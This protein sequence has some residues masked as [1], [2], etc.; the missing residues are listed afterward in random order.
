[1]IQR[2]QSL[3][4]FIAALLN[5]GML[6][7]NLYSAHIMV[8]GADTV[9]NMRINGP[10]EF[11]LLLLG[12]VIMIV[13]LVAIFMFKNRKKQKSI[14]VFSIVAVIA[15]IATLLMHVA[16][17]NNQTPA[18]ANGGYSVGAVLPVIS[19]IFLVMAIRGIN[20]DEKLVKSLDRLR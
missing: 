13:P 10:N 7:F 16:N 17:F 18:P 4:L 9:T 8:N 5:A 15:F 11:L 19:I 20:K 1:M 14:V 12:L 6:L 3:W 2:I